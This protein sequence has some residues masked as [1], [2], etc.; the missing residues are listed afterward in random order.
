MLRQGRHRWIKITQLSLASLKILVQ[1]KFTCLEKKTGFFF[2]RLFSLLVLETPQCQDQQSPR[3]HDRSIIWLLTQPSAGN[4]SCMSHW[5]AVRCKRSTPSYCPV[6]LEEGTSSHKK[7]SY[8]SAE[9]R[10]YSLSQ[11]LELQFRLHFGASV[12]L[13]LPFTLSTFQKVSPSNTILSAFVQI[14]MF[15]DWSLGADVLGFTYKNS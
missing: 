8:G 9:V 6:T 5:A 2:E 12:S 3:P 14:G 13:Y 7:K 1:F 11:E 15:S 4:S 10:R